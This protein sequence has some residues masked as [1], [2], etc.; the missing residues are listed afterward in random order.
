VEADCI[1][2]SNLRP[3]IDEDAVETAEQIVE[4]V[5]AEYDAE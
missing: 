1:I 2:G 3:G 4:E 5:L